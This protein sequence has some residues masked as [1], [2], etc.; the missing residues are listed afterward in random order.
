MSVVTVDASSGWF[1]WATSI[2]FCPF[3]SAYITL[4]MMWTQLH[5][6]PHTHVRAC[7]SEV[8]PRSLVIQLS[9]SIPSGRNAISDCE[10][11]GVSVCST[12]SRSQAWLSW[13]HVPFVRI[14]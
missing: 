8:G 2:V 6:T 1:V 13:V 5:A 11:V 9:Q 12:T 7:R 10:E 4:H 3:H 14:S